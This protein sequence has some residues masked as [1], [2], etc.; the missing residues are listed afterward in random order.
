MRKNMAKGLIAGAA[1][2]VLVG[3]KSDEDTARELLAN[4][5]QYY[6]A[7]QDETTPTPDRL[8]AGRQ[9]ITVL[10]QIVADY[11]TTDLGLQIAAG[12]SFGAVS[13][14]DLLDQIADIEKMLEY[15]LCDQQPTAACIVERL[16]SD[17][18]IFDRQELYRRANTVDDGLGLMMA[19]ASGDSQGVQEMARSRVTG[20]T[21]AMAIAMAP[22]SALDDRTISVVLN[23]FDDRTRAT[24]ALI[25][26][27]RIASGDDHPALRDIVSSFQDVPDLL[28]LVDPALSLAEKIDWIDRGQ[29]HSALG[30]REIENAEK[31]LALLGRLNNDNLILD[32]MVQQHG[33]AAVMDLFPDLSQDFEYVEASF[34]TATALSQAALALQDPATDPRTRSLALMFAAVHMPVDDL[35]SA[36]DALAGQ[37]VMRWDNL[38]VF[39]PLIALGHIGDRALFDAVMDI[40][41]EAQSRDVW[42]KTWDAGRMLAEGR[43]DADSA[44]VTDSRLF[45]STV[46]AAQG[47]ATREELQAFLLAMAQVAGETPGGDFGA[48]T[49]AVDIAQTAYNCGLPAVFVQLP[50]LTAEATIRPE[51]CDRARLGTT[52]DRW[53]DEDLAVFF[54]YG[55]GADGL[56]SQFIV[57]AAQVAPVRA[58]A[59]AR[60]LQDDDRAFATALLAVLL[61]SAPS[62]S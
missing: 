31:A 49:G 25:A 20:L 54:D 46:Y 29:Q 8:T 26:L 38:R 37:D 21:S 32:I 40:L 52:V 4:A 60:A 51:R 6:S 43:V 18:G 14:R 13:R 45:R 17:V 9:V 2:L 53:L 27:H 1:L 47:R 30:S 61:G 58:Y 41:T 59:M 11:G 34:G 24:T 36:V 55:F 44:L 28:T 16:A 12:G 48:P 62:G 5:L 39:A 42:E 3:C 50:G 19:F 23:A 7:M 57:E 35:R 10:D 33:A 15:E 56:A 22:I